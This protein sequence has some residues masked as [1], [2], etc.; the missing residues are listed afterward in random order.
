VQVGVV[1]ERLRE[2]VRVAT[3][4]MCTGAEVVVVGGE[5]TGPGIGAW[6]IYLE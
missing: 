6:T 4:G 5:Q 1:V 2:E 3:V